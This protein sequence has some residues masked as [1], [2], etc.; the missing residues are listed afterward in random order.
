MKYKMICNEITLENIFKKYKN[1]DFIIREDGSVISY[2]QF[3]A[4]VIKIRTKLE[5]FGCKKGNLLLIKIENSEEY[6]KLY[7]ACMLIGI[8]A[9][10]IDPNLPK[11]R[12]KYII[13]EIN[14]NYVI[15][16]IE[17][18]YK[19]KI[20]NKKNHFSMKND[21]IRNCLLLFSSGTTGKPKGIVHSVESLLSS[22]IS[23][24]AFSGI[25]SKTIVYHHFPMFYMA[26]IFNMFLCPMVKGAKIV[27]GKRFSAKS[28]LDFWDIPM[29]NSVNHLTIT[30]TMAISLVQI[31][32]EDKMVMQYIKNLDSILS[33]G[34]KLHRSVFEKFLLKFSIPLQNCYGVTE[35][36]GTI[37]YNNKEESLMQN[38]NNVGSSSN[39]IKFLCNGTKNKPE[40]IIVK[41]P[42]MMSGYFSNGN[43]EKGL[44]NGY[45]HT[46]D[47]G[48][49]ENNRL[50]VTG[51]KGDRIKKGGE[52]VSLAYIEDIL[53]KT[54]LVDEL[55]VV[56]IEDSFWGNQII[57]FYVKPFEISENFVNE[58]FVIFAQKFLTKIE[59]PDKYICL[60][61]MPKTSIG[62]IKKKTLMNNYKRMLTNDIK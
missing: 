18:I 37:T 38:E 61:E 48:Y 45:F 6:L 27:L 49:L 22:S 51:R 62:K 43:I 32:R 47:I 52:F 33:T 16:N 50:F 19:F 53:M 13:N 39:D 26:G 11:D 56:S 46:G 24:S 40:E 28:M 9:C 17:H 21:G 42:F 58:K 5:K 31:F 7:I 41:T 54:E 44:K 8:I 36:G 57:V 1:N 10:P 14:P 3:W 55:S 59:M 23:F 34:S 30:P 4:D 35:V 2:I 60:D 15:D 29:K 12:Y 20:N 25:N